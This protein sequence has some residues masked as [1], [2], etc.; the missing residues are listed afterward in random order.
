MRREIKFR[1]I[2]KDD[3]QWVYGDIYATSEVPMIVKH[4]IASEFN[5]FVVVD[6]DTV[7]QYT[8]IKDKND[9][10]IYDG[11]IVRYFKDELGIVK[12]VAGSFIIDGNTC[13]ES[14]LELG[15]EI[16]I[17]GNIYENKDL[18]KEK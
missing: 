8:G 9:K 17:V 18:L 11:D 15:G 12:F 14:F 10:E 1:G 16:E 7:G 6:E 3:K 5:N 13:Y 2:S 4:G